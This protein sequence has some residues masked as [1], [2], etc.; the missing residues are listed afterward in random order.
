[1]LT[2]SIVTA[3]LVCGLLPAAAA[4]DQELEKLLTDQYR[5]K[6]LALRHSFKSSSQQYNVE[7]KPVKTGEE[8][9]WTLYGRI[10][11]QKVVVRADSL[12][13]E[14]KRVV[15]MLDDRTK[16]FMPF[17]DREG[18]TIT[19]RL[20]AP[21]T[22]ADQAAAVLNQVFAMSPEDVVKS[23]P[24][25]WQDYLAQQDS[26]GQKM[27]EVSSAGAA[28]QQPAGN[29]GTS[30]YTGNERVFNLGA[31][32]VT[33]PKI[34]FNPE[35]DYTDAARKHSFQGVVGLNV[36]VDSSGAVRNVKIAHPL[37]FGLDENAV[38]TI[39]TWRFAPAMRDGQPVATLVYIEFDFRLF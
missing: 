20:N 6:I 31:S 11:V 10:A 5:D 27:D 35:P 25:Y 18:V 14:G 19:I 32:G 1:M 22:F 3:A 9:P 12:R 23:A 2:K 30:A 38:K 36:V 21:L 26:A 34:L 24:S 13:L 29:A 7:G 39:S 37:G 28:Q 4:C 16:R 8:G 33:A 17:R 15:Y